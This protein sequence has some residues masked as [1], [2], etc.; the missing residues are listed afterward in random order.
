VNTPSKNKEGT[1]GLPF[2]HTEVRIGPD[3]EVL[4]RGSLVMRGY[5]QN[6][7]LTAKTLDSEG[8]LHTGDRG[9]IDAEGF[10]T[11]KGRIK[12]LFKTS[13]GE[14]VAPVPIEQAICQAPLIE[15]AMVIAEGRKFA[16]CLLFP[17]K[18]VL[19]SLKAAHHQTNLSDETFLEGD[20]VHQE[21]NK[22]FDKINEHLNHWE[23]IHAYRFVSHPAT[24][25]SGELTPSMKIRR[26][27]VAQK[28]QQ[29]ID[30]M[31]TEEKR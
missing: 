23:Q 20:F 18:E 12:D 22:F 3:E 24:I 29:L 13:T 5:Y 4:V 1:V 2:K 31:Y 14:Y 21:M 7:E 19:D 30:A 17:N 25:E 27:I 16:S 28:Y 10:L 9:E 15:M 11:I 6:P 26:D 8:W